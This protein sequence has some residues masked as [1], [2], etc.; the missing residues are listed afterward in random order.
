M[1]PFLHNEDS[2]NVCDSFWYHLLKKCKSI[3]SILETNINGGGEGG[4][5]I[6]PAF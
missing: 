2:E 5:A 3:Q 1:L 6:R 4:F